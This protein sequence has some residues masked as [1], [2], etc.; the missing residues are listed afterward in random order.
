MEFNNIISGNKVYIM[1][2][3]MIAIMLTH[4]PFF[5][6]NYFV[7][8]F[9]MYGLWGVE[10]FLFVSGFGMVF[11]LRK[12]SIKT[13]YKNRAIRLLPSCLI[14]G[15]MKLFFY[16][17]G[18]EEAAH[19]NALLLVTNLYMWY[20]YAIV[21]YYLLSPI[22]YKLLNKWGFWVVAMACV[23][24]YLCRYIPFKDSSYFLINQL[25]W[26]T[27]RLPI[28][29]FGM[30]VAIKPLYFKIST[31]SI[32]GAIIFIVCMVLRAGSIMVKYKWN[33]PYVYTLLLFAT[34][35]LCILCSYIKVL[36]QK[37][38]C[39]PLLEFLG[40][41]SLEIYLIHVSVYLNIAR[42]NIFQGLNSY[43]QSVLAICFILVFTIITIIVRDFLVKRIMKCI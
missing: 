41:Y 28:F 37:I 30:Y 6:G 23:F 27:G 31:I 32:V 10:L 17:L 39:L 25:G 34:P 36:F 22:F 1:G 42:N 26:V 5:F 29:V 11:S 14:I 43:E 33:V 16:Y 12:N 3:A 38:K 7:D 13:F 21:V 4:Q 40:K 8:F 2:C 9:H 24:S 35:M 20:I 18:F 15:L 19:S